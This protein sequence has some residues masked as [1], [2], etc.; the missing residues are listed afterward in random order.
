MDDRLS[1]LLSAA[2]KAVD[3][4]A[5]ATQN[6]VEKGVDKAEQLTL[7]RRL[8]K[9]QQQLGSLVYAQQKSGEVNEGVLAYYI[10]KIDEIKLAMRAQDPQQ[11]ALT[12]HSCPRCGAEGEEDAMF[13]GRCG[14]KLP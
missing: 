14:A 10:A 13:C 6:L 12:V 2:G 4:T 3:T 9:A 1:K 11:D 5:K 8:A 7:Q